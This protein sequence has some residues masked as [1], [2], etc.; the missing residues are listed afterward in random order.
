MN[1]NESFELIALCERILEDSEVTLAEASELGEWL[2][3]HE[4][5]R[6]TWPGEVLAQPIQEALLD[7]MVNTAELHRMRPSC[8]GSRRSG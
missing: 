2:T 5:A 3:A 6:R 1:G 8:G 7:G 4:E